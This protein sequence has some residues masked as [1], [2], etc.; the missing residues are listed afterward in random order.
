MKKN[1]NNLWSFPS[2]YLAL[3]IIYNVQFLFF[4]GYGTIYSRIIIAFLLITSVYYAFYAAIHYSQSSYLKGLYALLLLFTVYGLLRIMMTSK[5]VYLLQIYNSLLP[6]FPIYVFTRK[7]VINK[8]YVLVWT[9]I[10]FVAATFQ[11]Y[12]YQ[13]RLIKE[14]MEAGSEKEEFTN[15]MGYFFLSLIPL[16]AFFSGKKTIQYIGLLYVMFFIIIAM[17][18]GALLIGAIC[19]VWFLLFSM[20][21]AKRSQKIVVV[22]FSVALIVVGT[23]LVQNMLESSDYFNQRIQETAEGDSSGRESRYRFLW[24]YFIKES[25]PIKF[26]VG[27]GADSTLRIYGGHAHNDWLEILIGQGLL[28]AVVYLF[29]WLRFYRTWRHTSFDNEVYLAMGLLLIIYF[30][31]SLFSMSYSDMS[32]YATFCLGYCLGR[33]REYGIGLLNNEEMENN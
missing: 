8:K 3:W 15:N 24:G 16:L 13:D 31:R 14:A 27:N 30:M 6:I 17:K 11:Y 5:H 1:G 29:Y 33:E 32:I 2:L 9:V 4:G 20:R 22:I 12:S 21:K 19:V 23:Y 10:F 26:L 18:R 28:G 7:G 25:S